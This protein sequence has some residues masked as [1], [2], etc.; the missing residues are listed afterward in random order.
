MESNMP[1]LADHPAS[2]T[3][4]LLLMG[5]PGSGK[6]GAL[7]SLAHAG[8]NLRI[9][10]L[11]N[12]LDILKNLLMDPKSPYSNTAYKNVK[13]V[14]LTE[15][16]MAISSRGG[17]EV[18][19]SATVWN[20]LSSLLTNWKNGSEDLGPI[21][22]WTEKEVLVI[23]SM[24]LAGIAAYNFAWVSQ[25]GNKNQDGRMI[26][27][28]AQSYL[29]YLMQCLYSE[30]VKCNVVVTAHVT[31][32]G[33]EMD[34]SHGYPMTI[35]SKLSLKIGRYF[36]SVLLLKSE[37]KNHRL[38]TVPTFKVEVK[39]SAPLRVKDSYDIRFGL[40]DYFKDVRGIEPAASSVVKIA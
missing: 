37:G 11:D 4:K 22:S 25:A 35:G 17:T 5:D 28:H 21:E 13:Y 6:T 36:N 27:F 38:Y 19:K 30:D 23:D 8:Y 7:A 31:F 14:T 16:K 15:R 24:T 40:A 3:T 1:D 32:L 33:D 18:P 20:R 10:D 29:E 12:G 2:N 39:T 34:I 9:V 26:Y